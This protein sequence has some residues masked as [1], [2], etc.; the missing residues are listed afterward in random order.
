MTCASWRALLDRPALLGALQASTALL[1]L[2]AQRD[3]ATEDTR[4]C[5]G[6]LCLRKALAARAGSSHMMSMMVL[7]SPTG[8]T[9]PPL[10]VGLDALHAIGK[11]NTTMIGSPD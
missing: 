8:G 11:C 9:G 4:D 10:T 6:G 2:G 1:D 5:L 3:I 7:A